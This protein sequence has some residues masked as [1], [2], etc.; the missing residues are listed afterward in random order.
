MPNINEFFD[1]KE[2]VNKVHSTLEP[3][4]GVRP[5]SKCEEDVDGGLWDPEK[6]QLSWTCSRGHPSY[7]QVN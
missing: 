3:I 6:L 2:N 4:D 1:K 5:C 7:Y